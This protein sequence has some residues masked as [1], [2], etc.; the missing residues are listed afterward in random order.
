MS[1]DHLMRRL[2]TARPATTEHGGDPEALFGRIVAEPGDP[3]LL[4]ASPGRLSRPVARRLRVWTRA[5]SGVLAASTLALAGVA[6]AGVF[7][8]SGSAAPPAFA[9]TRTGDGAVLVKLNRLESLPDANRHLAE[10]GIR[11]QVVVAVARGTAPVAGPVDCAPEAGARLSGPPLK[12]L[13]GNDGTE[14]V[15]PTHSGGISGADTY[16]VYRCVI[17][18]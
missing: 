17:Q 5:R 1:D 3:R 2:R 10:M 18:R 15:G 11:E 7:A 9:I 14:A 12:V 16:H 8:L 6:A 13:M 4:R